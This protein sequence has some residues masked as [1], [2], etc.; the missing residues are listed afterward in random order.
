MIA[1][2]INQIKNFSNFLIAYSGGLDSTVLLHQLVQLRDK[3]KLNLNLRVIHIHH[4]LNTFADY[5]LDHCKKQCNNWNLHL[6]IEYIRVE[7]KKIGIE[8]SARE[9]RY[10]VLCKHLNEKEVL[11]TGHHINDQCETFF[12]ALKRGS[13]PYGLS[14]MPNIRNICNN[15]ILLRPLLNQTQKNIKSWAINNHL[16]WID[17]ESNKNVK[18]DR[19][20]LRNK[21]LPIIYSRWPYFANSVYRSALIC[22]E[23]E[24]LLDELLSVSLQKIINKDGSL[25]TD[26]LFSISESYRNELLRRWIILQIKKVPSYKILITIWKEVINSSKDAL[27]KINIGSYEICR[28]RNAIYLVTISKSLKNYIIPWNKPWKTLLLP[29]NIGQIIAYDKRGKE[30]RKPFITEKVT[31]RFFYN[32]NRV[33]ILNR[34]GSQKIKKLWQESSIPVWQR[35]CIPLLFYDEKLISAIG[36]FITKDGF[37]EKKI[38]WNLFWK[39]KI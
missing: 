6:I 38:G 28:Y 23:Q 33:Y 9:L 8:A 18:Y 3:N 10:Y 22:R 2:L 31:I 21:I 36:V 14:S 39:N 4:G 19:N 26:Y 17:D 16:I 11:L 25:I 12:L 27:P 1:N 34:H 29:Q 32:H 37:C 13:G 5:W 24:K 30:I 15:K 35:Q 20:F 7:K